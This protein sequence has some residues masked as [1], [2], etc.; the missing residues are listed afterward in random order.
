M[1]RRQGTHLEVPALGHGIADGEAFDPAAAAGVRDRRPQGVPG[2]TQGRP[3][4]GPAEAREG[5]ERIGEPNDGSSRPRMH[6]AGRRHENVEPGRTTANL[7][8]RAGPS[9][10]SSPAAA[11][12]VRRALRGFFVGRFARSAGLP[13][14]RFKLDAPTPGGPFRIVPTMPRFDSTDQ[15]RKRFVGPAA[16]LACWLPLALSA[17]GGSGETPGVEQE[18]GSGGQQ[19]AQALDTRSELDGASSSVS[20]Q[21]VAHSEGPRDAGGE[22]AVV[23]LGAEGVNSV[24]QAGPAPDAQEPHG[25]ATGDE[26]PRTIDWDALEAALD[27]VPADL[28]LGVDEALRRDTDPDEWPAVATVGGDPV[29]TLREFHPN[30]GALMRIATIRPRTSESDAPVMHGPEW[31]YQE[32]GFIRAVQ[33]WKDDVAH[34]P[35]RQ[36][37]RVGTIVREG[38]FRDGVQDGLWREYSKQG[39][40]VSRSLFRNGVLDGP[41]EA[42]FSS[43]QAQEAAGYRAG[44]LHGQRT[45]WDRSGR[46]VLSETY[47]HGKHDGRFVQYHPGTADPREWGMFKDGLRVGT[48]QRGLVGGEVAETREFE[49]GQ[50]HGL[51]RV[52]SPG[53][54]LVEESHYEHGEKSG[55]SQTWYADGQ[56]QSQGRLDRGRRVG[57]WSYWKQDGSLNERWTGIYDDDVR[58][59]PL[60]SGASATD[61]PATGTG[62]SPGATSG[63]ASG[64]SSGGD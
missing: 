9:S 50:P 2:E 28:V 21:P 15:A 45:A 27:Q 42:W 20:G 61:T 44:E 13:P 26:V 64:A 16:R 25:P 8:S 39:Q 63:E 30:T 58:V 36:W 34:G 6:L 57:P 1:P 52:W 60:D 14:R 11:T 23:D 7:F 19:G 37:R 33:W 62:E 38:R 17:C 29:E 59:G 51:A 49:A 43:G 56:V 41:K 48:W 22:S 47:A 32:L 10:A 5:T 46:L 3:R 53:G 40:L 12:P 18:G 24:G 35:V 4:G 55:S 31:R 54:I